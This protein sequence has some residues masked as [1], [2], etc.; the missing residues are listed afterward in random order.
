MS[1]SLSDAHVFTFEALTEH[2]QD[3]GGDFA[4]FRVLRGKKGM[5][6]TISICEMVGVARGQPGQNSH[7][8]QQL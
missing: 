4:E 7:E 5:S 1:I 8:G 2:I 3:A 6:A